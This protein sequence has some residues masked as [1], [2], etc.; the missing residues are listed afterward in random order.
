LTDEQIAAAIDKGTVAFVRMYRS[1]LKAEGL[2]PP[3][4]K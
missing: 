1:K 3:D 4:P 2:N